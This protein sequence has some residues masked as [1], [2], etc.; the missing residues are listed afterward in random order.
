[1]STTW[2]RRC[3]DNHEGKE[4]EKGQVLF[5]KLNFLKKKN[6]KKQKNKSIPIQLIWSAI[7]S[8]KQND[9]L[10]FSSSDPSIKSR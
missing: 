5:L 7:N 10:D 4:D 3:E 9:K 8:E 6:N 2:F 1:M